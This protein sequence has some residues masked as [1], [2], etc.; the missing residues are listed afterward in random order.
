[1]VSNTGLPV[2]ASSAT[3]LSSSHEIHVA[4]RDRDAA[5]HRAAA[6]LERAQIEGRFPDARAG[7]GFEGQYL[8][9]VIDDRR[10]RVHHAVDDDGRCLEAGGVAGLDECDRRERADVLR[11]DLV[12]R[13]IPVIGVVL[14]AQELVLGVAVGAGEHLVGERDV[15]PGGQRSEAL[16]RRRRGADDFVGLPAPSWSECACRGT[17]IRPVITGRLPMFSR[18]ATSS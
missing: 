4:V 18:K 3:S 7:G 14:A 9:L 11:G 13:R 16:R 6:D 1:V 10:R 2:L 17:M 5:V 12:E 8:H 15:G